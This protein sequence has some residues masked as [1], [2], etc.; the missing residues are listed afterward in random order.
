MPLLGIRRA[1]CW[2]SLE[3]APCCWFRRKV[4]LAS[5]CWFI[6]E[7]ALWRFV[8]PVG[9]ASSGAYAPRVDRSEIGRD[10]AAG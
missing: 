9:V 2:L 3:L 6:S 10:C 4:V 1:L 7:L 8:E 5:R